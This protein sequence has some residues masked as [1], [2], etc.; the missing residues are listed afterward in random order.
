MNK[1]N[2]TKD[3]RRKTEKRLIRKKDRM[4]DLI[5]KNGG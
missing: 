5:M 4:K 1:T 3:T 2:T